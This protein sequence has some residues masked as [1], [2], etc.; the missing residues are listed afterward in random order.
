[1]VKQQVISLATAYYQKFLAVVDAFSTNPNE[2]ARDVLEAP[3][4]W[5]SLTRITPA[6][7]LLHIFEK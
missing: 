1:M 2:N 5:V 4:K 3:Q 6:Q 7:Q